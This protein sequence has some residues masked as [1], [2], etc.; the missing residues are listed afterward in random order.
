MNN[1]ISGPI[2]FYNLTYLGE[3]PINNK[4]SDVQALNALT[5]ICNSYVLH[6][7]PPPTPPPLANFSLPSILQSTVQSTIQSTVNNILENT[8]NSEDSDSIPACVQLNQPLLEKQPV[9]KL[10]LARN[11][12]G[13]LKVFHSGKN[14]DDTDSLQGGFWEVS[15]FGENTGFESKSGEKR[16]ICGL[17]RV[18]KC[19]FWWFLDHF[20]VNFNHFRSFLAISS[21]FRPFSVTLQHSPKPP[22]T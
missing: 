20:V 1:E 14:I 2:T 22:C 16:V 10:E 6:P 18:K 15:Y 12:D 8:T 3:R 11:A 5:D 13:F 4:S 21:N 19:I 7:E 9:S 17:H